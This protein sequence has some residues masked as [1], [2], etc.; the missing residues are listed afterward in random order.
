MG[1]NSQT[2]RLFVLL[3]CYFSDSQTKWPLVSASRVDHDPVVHDGKAMT[4]WLRNNGGFMSD[5]LEI[6]RRVPGDTN[7]PTG[8]FAVEELLPDEVILHIPQ[9]LYLKI[10]EKQV[11]NFKPHDYEDDDD[12]NDIDDQEY[13]LE[14]ERV[15]MDVYFANSCSLVKRL[16][17]E[18]ILYRSSPSSSK[19]APYISYLE[20]T[21]QKGQLPAAYSPEGK[22][23]LRKIQGI[24]EKKQKFRSKYYGRSPLPPMDLVD[25]IDEH[26]VN[27]GC[28]H[29]NNT[30]A[31]HAAELVIQRG[32][33]LELIPIWDMVN[34]EVK[35]RVNV[36]TN[37]LRSEEGLVVRAKQ[38][39]AAGEEILYT[40]NYCTDCNNDG[41]WW[42]APGIYR[43]FGFLEGYPQ[44]WP[45]QDQEVYSQIWKDLDGDE[46]RYYATFYAK[47]EVA[48]IDEWS[49]YL[50]NSTNICAPDHDG[51]DF[52]KEQL[53][54]LQN[55]DFQS[56]V[57][58]LS[59]KH[60]RTM[61]RQYYKALLVALSSIIEAAMEDSM[62]G[63]EEELE[64][65]CLSKLYDQK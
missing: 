34:H 8:V 44:D 7:S 63:G 49:A 39:I 17:D 56:E 43:D 26:F 55:F 27:K 16:L 36:E 5:K 22:T 12:D 28:F 19:F 32:F 37:S 48:A 61:I 59:S 3:S 21:Q 4:I 57:D 11:L 10:P 60:E 47:A 1:F 65:L 40:Y 13:I 41:F 64:S 31:Y 42:G 25:W 30:D 38:I 6:R 9:E 20:K 53:F 45:F 52:F 15:E 24:D 50:L 58:K 23:L 54:R 18:T 62:V 51:L 35:N 14:I 29:A 46:E 33:D 2:S